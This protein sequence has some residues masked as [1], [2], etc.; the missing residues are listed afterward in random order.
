[1]GQRQN[2]RA[3]TAAR[4]WVTASGQHRCPD[5]TVCRTTP[6]Q[7]HRPGNL[8]GP[9]T[10]PRRPCEPHGTCRGAGKSWLRSRP[11]MPGHAPP[12]AHTSRVSPPRLSSFGELEEP[13]LHKSGCSKHVRSAPNGAVCPSGRAGIFRKKDVSDHAESP[14]RP[15]M[16]RAQCYCRCRLQMI[17]YAGHLTGSPAPHRP[18]RVAAI[19]GSRLA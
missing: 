16:W 8:R 5:G 6:D 1:M 7:S 4:R 12:S 9:R 14:N 11:G 18:P 3:A 13:S 17:Q 10:Q 19:G 2:A 15:S